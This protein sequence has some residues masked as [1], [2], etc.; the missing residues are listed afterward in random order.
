[1]TAHDF[2]QLQAVDTALDAITNRRLRL[3]EL[4][5][6]EG[7]KAGLEAIEAAMA[8]AQARIDAAQLAIEAAEHANHELTTKRTRLE[9]Q[10]KTVIATREAEALI[11][12][13]ATINGQRG[14]LDDRE[15]AALDEQ[16]AG[17]SELAALQAKVPALR[18][19]CDLTGA[20]LADALAALEVEVAGL[21]AEREGLVA[22]MSAADLATYA[23]AR[24]QF[25]GVGV[26]HLE[27]SHCSG[28]HMDLS[29]AELDQVKAPPAGALSECPQC[30]R[31]LVR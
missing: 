18:A 1:M 21:R 30:G 15:L 20:A 16:A 24:K 19:A 17:E 13:I 26:A 23:H 9:A 28:C 22:T 2:L 29:P 12:Q 5:A 8:A 31:I 25:H 3:P 4:L 27:G 14:E 7:D 6:H 10:L 11:S